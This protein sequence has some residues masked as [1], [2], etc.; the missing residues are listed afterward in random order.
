[1]SLPTLAGEPTLILPV[2]SGEIQ[3]AEP[4]NRPARAQLTTGR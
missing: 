4:L 2:V 1:V 3:D